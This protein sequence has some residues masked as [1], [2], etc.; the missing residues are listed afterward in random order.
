M[1]LMQKLPPELEEIL[2]VLE[3]PHI[4]LIVIGGIAMRLHGCAH[5]TDDVDISYA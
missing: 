5:I 3:A 2:R 1:A 4:R